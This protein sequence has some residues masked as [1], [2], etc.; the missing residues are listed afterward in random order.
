M[1]PRSRLAAL[2]ASPIFVVFMLSN[3]GPTMIAGLGFTIIAA[4]LAFALRID[5][6]QPRR[7]SSLTLP[8]LS[9]VIA[10]LACASYF[11]AQVHFKSLSQPTSDDLDAVAHDLS[12]NAHDLVTDC[13]SSS[14]SVE[15]ST[16]SFLVWGM[17]PLFLAL[18]G[19]DVILVRKAEL[20]SRYIRICGAAALIYVA[21]LLPDV[22]LESLVSSRFIL[23]CRAVFG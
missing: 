4:L 1:A 8:L 10:A 14:I 23:L 18:A 9:L 19:L 17:I 15:R 13:R 6:A 7:W 12:L 16:R 3:Y 2:W 22:R 11:L 20:P 5:P 21:V